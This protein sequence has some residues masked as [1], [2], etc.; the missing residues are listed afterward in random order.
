MITVPCNWVILVKIA[1]EGFLHGFEIFW[2]KKIFCSS[3]FTLK[4]YIK[5]FFQM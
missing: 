2:K 1:Q 5:L 4:F 3:F